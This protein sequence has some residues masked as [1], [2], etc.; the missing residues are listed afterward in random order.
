MQV[1]CLVYL[2]G[3]KGDS[4]KSNLSCKTLNSLIAHL[5]RAESLIDV[6]Q[7]LLIASTYYF[8]SCKQRDRLYDSYVLARDKF[9]KEK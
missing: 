1:F 4:L 3:E 8:M 5:K 2:R 7:I 6:E 9:T